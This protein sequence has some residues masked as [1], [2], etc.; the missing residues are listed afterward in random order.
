MHY[1]IL[2]SFK[3]AGHSEN[4]L[5]YF[6]RKFFFIVIV[7]NESHYYCALWRFGFFYCFVFFIHYNQAQSLAI[8]F[9]FL[10]GIIL[11]WSKVWLVF[12]HVCVEIDCRN[13]TA[14]RQATDS[15]FYFR[16]SFKF[17]KYYYRMD[18]Y[19]CR[20]QSRLKFESF[21]SG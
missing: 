18:F 21:R 10:A 19:L 13:L 15:V 1:Q 20:E 7:N 3:F 4:T 2:P 8:F 5:Y 6:L 9:R 16:R 14:P 12:R 11:M 17:K